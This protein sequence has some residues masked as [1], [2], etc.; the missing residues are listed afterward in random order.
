[1]Y[2]AI[3]QNYKQQT[4]LW[5]IKLTNDILADEGYIISNSVIANDC[6]QTL[7]ILKDSMTVSNLSFILF[8]LLSFAPVVT[9]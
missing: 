6:Y 7:K 8:H 5:I 9:V 1:M 2:F 3:Q 4:E